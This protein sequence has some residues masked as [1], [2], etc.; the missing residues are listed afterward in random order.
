MVYLIQVSIYVSFPH[1]PLSSSFL[2]FLCFTQ[3]QTETS[4]NSARPTCHFSFLLLVLL[5]LILFGSVCFIPFQNKNKN[6]NKI[7]ILYKK[8]TTILLFQSLLY[9]LFLFLI[10]PSCFL[11]VILNLLIHRT[12]LNLGNIPSS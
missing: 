5:V 7:K 11:R 1:T 3:F 4:R 10:L 9:H 8:K 12:P 6:K 2:Y